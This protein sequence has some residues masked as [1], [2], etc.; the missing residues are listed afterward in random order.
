M[1]NKGNAHAVK[2]YW[3]IIAICL[4][5]LC[6]IQFVLNAQQKNSISRLEEEIVE[7]EKAIEDYYYEAT[8]IIETV[9]SEARYNLYSAEEE[10]W[11]ADYTEEALRCGEVTY[12]EVAEQYMKLSE[13]V[14]D[15]VYYAE[16]KP[17][18]LENYWDVISRIKWG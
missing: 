8:S 6:I 4:A 11:G 9:H 5:L 7:Y 10:A 18:E 16:Q 17:P 15:A 2:P 14:S 1:D 12:R 3:Q 13:S